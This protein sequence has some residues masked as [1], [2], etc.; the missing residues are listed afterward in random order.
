MALGIVVE[1]Q[2]VHLPEIEVVGLQTTQRVLELAH[3]DLRVAPMRAHLR[4]QEDPIPTTDER[5]AHA[6]LALPVVVFPGVIHEGDPRVD[7]LM[8]DAGR[9]LLRGYGPEVIAAES[10]GRDVLSRAAKGAERY[11][12]GRRWSIRGRRA[13]VWGTLHSGGWHDES[14][15]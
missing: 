3:P 13:G 5:L 10:N 15:R 6:L 14:L 4:H 8:D 11:L 2:L 7:G 1:R 12:G 9:F